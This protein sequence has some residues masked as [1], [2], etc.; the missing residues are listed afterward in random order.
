VL[1]DRCG[2]ER[3]RLKDESI[4]EPGEARAHGGAEHGGCAWWIRF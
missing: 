4:A 2:G 1:A 3:A